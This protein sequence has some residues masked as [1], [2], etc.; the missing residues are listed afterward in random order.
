M[1]CM[2]GGAPLALSRRGR[3]TAPAA[4]AA[5]A[6][7]L[8]PRPCCVAPAAPCP[9]TACGGASAGCAHGPPPWVSPA[10]LP[11]R[12]RSRTFARPLRAAPSFCT[13]ARAHRHR[14][15]N[16]AGQP[17][18]RRGRPGCR[19]A[20]ATALLPRLAWG[21]WRHGGRGGSPPRRRGPWRR[22][23]WPSTCTRLCRLRPAHV[24]YIMVI[25]TAR[26]VSARPRARHRRSRCALWGVLVVATWDGAP[27]R[28]LGPT[29]MCD[30]APRH[31]I[32]W[33]YYIQSYKIGAPGV[34]L[35]KRG[36]RGLQRHARRMGVGE[37]G[38]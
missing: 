5:F 14:Q 18:P 34:Q 25:S 38:G 29:W 1:T 16:G 13:P 4:R 23:R 3:A 35:P 36:R 10:L 28:W 27:I 17:R 9:R 2:E 26:P 31:L 11:Q 20:S 6:A 30:G 19:P 12:G 24:G 37:C 32:N 7:A 21:G 22:R 15:R 33:F 8:A